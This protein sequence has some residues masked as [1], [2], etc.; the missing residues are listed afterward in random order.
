MNVFA[1][2]I[3]STLK[4]NPTI[5]I[6]EKVL[7]LQPIGIYDPFDLLGGDSLKKIEI[8][9]LIHSELQFQE[10]IINFILANTIYDQSKIIDKTSG[11]TKLIPISIQKYW[12]KV[13]VPKSKK[14]GYVYYKDVK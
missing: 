6:W 10:P 2:T 11:S 4:P 13:K 9:H 7:K 5:L 3:K 8:Y 14:T 1:A 12:R